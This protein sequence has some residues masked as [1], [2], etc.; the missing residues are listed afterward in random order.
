MSWRRAAA[1]AA[2][3]QS[4]RLVALGQLLMGRSRATVGCSATEDTLKQLAAG[5]VTAFGFFGHLFRETLNVKP[6]SSLYWPPGLA[7]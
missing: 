3:D 7:N 1:L 2:E 5:K 4:E 6:G